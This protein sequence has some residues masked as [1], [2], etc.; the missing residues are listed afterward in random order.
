[1]C[2]Y[3][4]IMINTYLADNC[5]FKSNR[6]VQHIRDHNKRIRYFGVNVHN[7]NDVE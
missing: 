6:F 1:M 7:Q 2:V 4:G 3:N 5:A